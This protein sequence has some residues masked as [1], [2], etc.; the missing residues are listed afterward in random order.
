MRLGKKCQKSLGERYIFVGGVPRSGTT[1]VQK[2]LDCHPQ[3]CGIPEFKYTHHIIQLRNR[4]RR[5]VDNQM[6][7]A[8]CSD[9]DVDCYIRSLIDSF[10][11]PIIMKHHVK[12]LSEKTPWN[13]L[14]FEELMELYPKAR[15]IHVVRDP[16]AVIN[17]MIMVR[18]RALKKNLPVPYFTKTISES[19]RTT[20]KCL[21]A[22]FD[23]ARKFPDRVL[24]ILYEQLLTDLTGE[25][26][27]ICQFLALD[28]SSEMIDFNKR[29]NLAEQSMMVG[30]NAA[31]YNTEMYHQN[32]LAKDIQEWKDLLSAKERVAIQRAFYNHPDL[33]KLGY[34]FNLAYLSG[35]R[36][37]YGQSVYTIEA[38]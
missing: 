11:T 2:I 27:K 9:T 5:S 18:K 7:D 37:F 8:I 34:E 24:T 28:W 25:T 20:R 13:V 38:F 35:L 12:Y 1:L 4:M 29:N 21:D 30:S 31:Y 36:K 33:R 23:A 3:I 22:G 26:K 19:I 32:P 10:F 14:V 15:F 17:S 6:I 16:R